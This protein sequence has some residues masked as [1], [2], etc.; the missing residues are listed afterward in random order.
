VRQLYVIIMNCIIIDDDEITCRILHE[1]INRT[2]GLH[3][4]ATFNSPIEI[5][6]NPQNLKDIDLIFLDVVM[7]TMTGFEFLSNSNI[8]QIIIIVSAKEN[9][10]VE[11]FTKDVSDFLL[12]PITYTRF[13]TSIQ[14]AYLKVDTKLRYI[15][16]TPE[17]GV[18]VKKNHEHVKIIYYDIL[19]IESA[20]NYITINTASESHTIHLTIKAIEDK[21]PLQFKRI[22]RSII[23]NT[24]SIKSIGNRML[25]INKGT[26]IKF[27]PIGRVYAKNIIDNLNS[28]KD[29]S[30]E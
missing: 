14:K 11:A 19:W 21:L 30:C 7:P 10:A 12:K 15:D 3:H 1:F 24:F 5:I 29:S 25:S 9:H 20:Q 18:F 2:K 26:E 13:L 6:K 8:H 23:V 4:V 27:L 22:H 28:I 16:Q 17:N